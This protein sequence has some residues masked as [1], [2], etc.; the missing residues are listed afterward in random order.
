MDKLKIGSLIS[1]AVLLIT[2]LILLRFVGCGHGKSQPCPEVGRTTDTVTIVKKSTDTLHVIAEGSPLIR[3]VHHHD[4]ITAERHDTVMV[5]I[6]G[7]PEPLAISS[8]D[9]LYYYDSIF[10][11]DTCII[12]LR[13][14]VANNEVVYRQ[15][16]YRDLHPDKWKVV[17]NNITVERKSA[18]FKFYPGV[19]ASAGGNGFDVGVG[20]L[21]IFNDWVAINYNYQAIH[22]QHNAGVY[23]KLSFKK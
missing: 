12:T 13:E 20:A 22:N 4:T 23:I 3:A 14:R 16:K 1:N 9:T 19:E 5:L 7:K 17:T 10:K 15:L 8:C 21:G 18:L 2:V 6:N 11:A